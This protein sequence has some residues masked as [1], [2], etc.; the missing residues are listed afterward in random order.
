ML[1]CEAAGVVLTSV[2]PA[3]WSRFDTRSRAFP[4][5]GEDQHRGVQ[6]GGVR[7]SRVLGNNDLDKEDIAGRML[8]LQQYRSR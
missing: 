3:R 1:S 7:P 6:A 8:W 2:S 4:A 5:A